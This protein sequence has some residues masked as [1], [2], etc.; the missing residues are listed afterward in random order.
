MRIGGFDF[1][2]GL[3][4]TL[5]TLATLSLLLGLGSWQLDRA[6]WKQALIDTERETAGQSP[7]PLL[8]VVEAG[9][10][11][12]FRPVLARGRYELDRQLL[13]DNRIHEGRAGYHVLTPLRLEGYDGVV[14]VNRG[15]LPMGRTRADL[16]PLP[17]PDG[18][19]PVA[20]TIAR[21]PEKIFRLDAA[22]ERVTGWP[23]VIQHVDFAAIEQRLGH[24]VLPV[25]LQLANEDPHGFTRDWK[26]VYGITPDKH[27]AYAMQWF[28]LALVLVLIYAGVNTRR[29]DNR[30]QG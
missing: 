20:G 8:A 29:I 21:L 4:P 7:Q 9:G 27:H 17:G 12:D 13:V 22:E 10:V 15:W 19:V 11:L 24:A 2:P 16:P 5:A 6:A 14:L 18:V 28:T 23:Q 26:P 30:A 25:I 1:N 3:W